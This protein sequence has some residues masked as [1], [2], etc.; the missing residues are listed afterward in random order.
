MEK[1]LKLEVFASKTE[2]KPV[3]LYAYRLI[4]QNITDSKYKVIRGACWK[5]RNYNR[6]GVFENGE[7]IFSTEPLNICI[8][9]KDFDLEYLGEKELEVKSNRRVYEALI[10]YYISK[11][12]E[13]VFIADKYRKYSCKNDITSRFVMTENGFKTFSSRNKEINLERKYGVL[14]LYYD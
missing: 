3:T 8:P 13:N 5:V 4:S 1:D 14:I 2:I 11:N 12:L 6:C 9:N 7:H 10:K